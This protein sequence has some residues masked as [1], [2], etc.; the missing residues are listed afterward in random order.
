MKNHYDE[1]KYLKL[2]SKEY[3]NKHIG[4]RVIAKII[5]IANDLGFS[6]IYATIYSFN[7]QSQNMFKSVGFTKIEEEKYCYH[8]TK[9]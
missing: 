6:E 5:E 8:I 9:E 7:I 3:Q 4:R 2:L 1:E